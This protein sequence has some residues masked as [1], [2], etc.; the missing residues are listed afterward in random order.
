MKKTYHITGYAY[1][2]VDADVLAIS[3][4]E[5]KEKYLDGEKNNELGF[6]YKLRIHEVIKQE[7]MSNEKELTENNGI[8]YTNGN[9]FLGK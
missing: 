2:P 9:Y 7:T 8:V 6:D 3:K 1:V 4:K 5:A